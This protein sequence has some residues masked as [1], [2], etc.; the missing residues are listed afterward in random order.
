[1]NQYSVIHLSYLD[2]KDL[3]SKLDHKRHE[4]DGKEDEAK[5]SPTH[6]LNV[7]W[8]KP[9]KEKGNRQG[10]AKTMLKV[11]QDSSSD[12]EY[13]CVICCDLI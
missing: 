7:R 5:L 4:R 13:L 9:K 12:E 1:M 10:K 8:R 11:S 3:S 2:S 6:Q